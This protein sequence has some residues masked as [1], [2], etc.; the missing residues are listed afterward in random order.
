MLLTKLG[1]YLALADKAQGAADG[2]ARSPF[3]SIGLMVVLFL[4]MYMIIIR[5]QKKKQK[6]IE[7][8]RNE[9]MPGNRV[10]TIGGFV[11]KVKKVDDDEIYLVLNDDTKH[12]VVKRWAIQ[13][14][15]DK[16]EAKEIEKKSKVAQSESVPEEAVE[17]IA[18]EK[19]DSVE[20]AKNLDEFKS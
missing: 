18:P 11:G 16:E 2:A 4:I 1:T 8:M 5:P 14:V 20:E 10:T 12:F 13:S 6:K 19:I 15:L 9:L 7:E 17:E 3:Y